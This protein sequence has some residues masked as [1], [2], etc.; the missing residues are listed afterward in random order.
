MAEYI[1]REALLRELKEKHDDMMQDK[2]YYSKK[3]LWH[4]AL[5]YART[6]SIVEC[7]PTAD[8]VE[9]RRGRWLPQVLLG[10]REWD[11]SECKTLG[12]PTWKC[13][14]VCGAIMDRKGEGE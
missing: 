14:P 5:S 1:E 12:V 3:K 7:Q 2:E 8:V 11:C 6:V 10:H 9:V 13:C 4:E